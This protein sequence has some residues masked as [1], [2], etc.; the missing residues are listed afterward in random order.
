M[1]TGNSETGF[2]HEVTDEIMPTDIYFSRYELHTSLQEV[3]PVVA[4]TPP[5]MTVEIDMAN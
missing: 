2:T 1:E 4:V 3:I 5:S